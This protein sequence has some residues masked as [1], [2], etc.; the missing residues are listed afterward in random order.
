MT[1]TLLVLK[2]SSMVRQLL[3]WRG[4]FFRPFAGFNGLN[5]AIGHIDSEDGPLQKYRV[6]AVLKE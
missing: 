1:Q 3:L 5:N 2:W 4:P 6:N